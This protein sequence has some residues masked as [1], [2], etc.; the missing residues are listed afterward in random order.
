MKTCPCISFGDCCVRYH[1]VIRYDGYRKTWC[2]KCGASRNK[3]S[4]HESCVVF[5]W[6]AWMPRGLKWSWWRRCFF[7][8]K[9]VEDKE[10][11]MPGSQLIEIP[12]RTPLTVQGGAPEGDQQ[13]S[14]KDAEAV[15][16]DQGGRRQDST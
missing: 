1:T 9:Q 7:S 4:V 11:Q 12:A 5:L 8:Q 10:I 6:D 16:K 13:T 2:I 3:R 14:H 15:A